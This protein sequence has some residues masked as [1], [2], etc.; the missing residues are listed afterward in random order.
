MF[1]DFNDR[2]KI[3]KNEAEKL[4]L[5]FFWIFLSCL[6]QGPIRF[7]FLGFGLARIGLARIGFLEYF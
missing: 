7:Q 5:D 2:M 3:D 4:G 6:D 1:R